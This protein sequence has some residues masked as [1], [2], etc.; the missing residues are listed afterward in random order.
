MNANAMNETLAENVGGDSEVAGAM[1]KRGGE[2]DGDGA[3]FESHYAWAGALLSVL[4]T[5]HSQ[6]AK[7]NPPDAV[8]VSKPW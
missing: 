7:G 3:D 1:V 5:K 4:R 8:E 6:P 2:G